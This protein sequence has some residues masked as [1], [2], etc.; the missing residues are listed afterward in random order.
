MRSLIALALTLAFAAPVGAWEV[1]PREKSTGGERTSNEVDA[2]D[3]PYAPTTG[4]DWSSVP[5]ES[6]A[7][8]DTLAGNISAIGGSSGAASVGYAPN[9]GTDWSVTPGHVADGLDELAQRTTDDETALAALVAASVGYA[10][11]DGTDW[12]V[13]PGHVADGLD[14][15]AQ[16]TTDDETA[17]AALVAASV[18]FVGVVP[19][20]WAPVVTEAGAALDQ[21]GA[22]VTA[23]I[24]ALAALDAAGVI[25]GPGVD[26]H[27]DVVPTEVEGALDE[28]AQRVEDIAADDIAYVG[29][30]PGDWAPVVAEAEDALNQIAARLT[31]GQAGMLGLT[32][33]VDGTTPTLYHWKVVNHNGVVVA[34]THRIMCET[35]T[36]AMQPTDWID[37]ELSTPGGAGSRESSEPEA[38]GESRVL[39]KTDAT[40]ILD[41]D[42][43]VPLLT[44]TTFWI[45]C[46]GQIDNAAA[47]YGIAEGIIAYV[48]AGE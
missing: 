48:I 32:V 27:W 30:V 37:V 2:T 24:A 5:D 31:A 41:V 42:I 28:L 47:P 4:A 10:P 21:L 26:A 39:F 36:I 3:V 22:R 20:D 45:H 35:L 43:N 14:E 23:D 46:E 9:D 15:L 17:L 6:G 29:A 33:A 1:F 18:A 38:S 25:Y 40:G 12:S 8:L 34:G 19:G 13:T 7:A 44:G 11:N 16:R